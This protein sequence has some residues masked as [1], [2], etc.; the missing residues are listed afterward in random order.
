MCFVLYSATIL[1]PLSSLQVQWS[2]GWLAPNSF[3]RA[4]AGNGYLRVLTLET[5]ERGLQ[6]STGIRLEQATCSLA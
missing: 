3:G 4:E 2:G 5:R 1:P 6:Q